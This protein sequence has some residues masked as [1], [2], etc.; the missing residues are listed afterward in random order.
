M[1]VLISTTLI[2][3]YQYR[4]PKSKKKR[5]RKKWSKNKA[6]YREKDKVVLYKRDILFVN[7]SLFE[8]LKKGSIATKDIT[9]YRYSF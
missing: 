6:N 1:K 8:K 4:F 5:I 2:E 9:F 7:P 3:F